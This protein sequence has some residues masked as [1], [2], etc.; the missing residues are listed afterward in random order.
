MMNENE[1]G[2]PKGLAHQNRLYKVL[3]PRRGYLFVENN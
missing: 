2:V 1:K 3:M